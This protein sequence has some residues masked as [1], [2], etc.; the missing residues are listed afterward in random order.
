MSMRFRGRAVL[1]ADGAEVT[2]R[3]LDALAAI[4]RE[5]SMR[6]AAGALGIS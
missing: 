5:G 3:L 6:K 2:R 1:V 4:A